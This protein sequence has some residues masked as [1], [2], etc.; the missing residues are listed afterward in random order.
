MPRPLG[1]GHEEWY[2]PVVLDVLLAMVSSTLDPTQATHP[3]LHTPPPPPPTIFV[4]T[5]TLFS[6][7]VTAVE[8]EPQNDTSD[9]VVFGPEDAKWNGYFPAPCSSPIRVA[10]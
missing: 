10:G 2:D 6:H 7:C 8:M 9:I 4:Y 1:E 3:R 5:H